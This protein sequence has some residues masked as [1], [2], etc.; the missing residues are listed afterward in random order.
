MINYPRIKNIVLENITDIILLMFL[1]SIGIKYVY[2]VH[3]FLD[4]QL[5]DETLYLNNGIHLLKLGI[6]N[7]QWASLYSIWYFI[8][9][10]IQTDSINVYFLNLKILTIALPLVLYIFLRIR[11][12]SRLIS[13]SVGFFFLV[14]SANI[15]VNPKVSHFAIVVIIVSLILFSMVKKENIRWYIIIWGALLVSYVRPELFLA[16][17]FLLPFVFYNTMKKHSLLNGIKSI[18]VFVFSISIIILT[19]GIPL[20]N[21]RRSFGAF[22]QH[23][24]LNWV[25]WNNSK[26]NPWV[27]AHDIVH[28]KFGN[29]HSIFDALLSNP[30]LFFKHILSNISMLPQEFHN[31]INY[32]VFSS[33][34]YR[35]ENTGHLN[36][37]LHNYYNYHY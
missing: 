16:F 31:L 6:P 36:F 18:S 13:F 37:N 30:G 10:L 14:S 3:L 1:L 4:I 32:T 23:F 2:D 22:S 15:V 28:K 7:P 20:G 35:F 34:H 33:G 26:L 24:S 17:V 8:L 21:G 9:S 11:G 29:V 12:V 25:R 27:D 5:K 19:L